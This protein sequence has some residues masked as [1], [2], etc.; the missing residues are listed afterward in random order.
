MAD[1]QHMVIR[2][3]RSN[4]GEALT[5]RVHPDGTVETPAG[6]RL[7]MGETW[8]AD[9]V[10]L[11]VGA[12]LSERGGPWSGPELLIMQS[13]RDRTSRMRCP[14][15]NAAGAT[16]MLG[17]SRRACDI[18]VSDEHVSRV[19]LKLQVGETGHTIEDME[20]KWGTLI[21][22]KRLIGRHNLTHGDEIR[23]GTSLLKYL[24]NWDGGQPEPMPETALT[25]A[26]GA[27]PQVASRVA[28]R[29]RMEKLPSRASDRMPNVLPPM[30]RESVP[31][32]WIGVGIGLIIALIGMIMYTVVTLLWPTA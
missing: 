24:L 27:E 12:D 8:S 11:R 31:P 13:E 9:G 28:T 15:P 26:G 23:I 19:H 20:S 25:W 4:L 2:I 17:R 18:V 5:L 22:G 6:S 3:S 14:L 10:E 1:S 21:N 16:L 29:D 32:L 30:V 7:A